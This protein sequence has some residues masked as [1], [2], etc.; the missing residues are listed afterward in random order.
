MESGRIPVHR[1][2]VLVCANNTGKMFLY[3]FDYETIFKMTRPT[4]RAI[5]DAVPFK[6]WSDHFDKN[7]TMDSYAYQIS[8][9]NYR[10]FWFP[11]LTIKGIQTYL[12]ILHSDFKNPLKFMDVLCTYTFS[13]NKFVEDA[14]TFYHAYNRVYPDSI[15]YA[16]AMNKLIKYRPAHAR[17]DR[18]ITM[19]E[20]PYLFS[21]QGCVLFHAK[22]VS[23]YTEDMYP[24]ILSYDYD[25]DT[26]KFSFILG[27]A[28][29][30]D[31]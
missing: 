4:Y 27:F 20:T 31:K 17:K 11:F 13:R 29:Q 9:Y 12:D 15:L 1:D 18:N 5:M 10:F 7:I 24:Q 3:Y 21:E 22:D 25:K 14:Y 23:K 26:L 16:L 28:R 30:F 19:F 8:S 2:G 6:N